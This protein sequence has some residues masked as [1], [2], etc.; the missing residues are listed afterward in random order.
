MRYAHARRRGV[1]ESPDRRAAL[2][3]WAWRTGGPLRRD[4]VQARGRQKGGVKQGPEGLP[5]RRWLRGPGLG[6]FWTGEDGEDEGLSLPRA[7]KWAAG[8]GRR[9]HA[10]FDAWTDASGVDCGRPKAAGMLCWADPL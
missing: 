5:E 2:S 7:L 1:N 4:P 9:I 6:I 8:G 10:A 3:A